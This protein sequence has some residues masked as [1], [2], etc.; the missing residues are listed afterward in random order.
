MSTLQS[1]PQILLDVES[2]ACDTGSPHLW[3]LLRVLKAYGHIFYYVSTSLARLHNLPEESLPNA[4]LSGSSL[5]GI[6]S[7][8]TGI[9]ATAAEL[10]LS[11]TS[12]RVLRLVKKV[13]KP[14]EPYDIKIELRFLSEILEDELKAKVFL[15]I[16]EAAIDAFDS[17][18]LFG[19]DV[20]AAF[21]SAAFD[22]AEAGSCF[23]CGRY[24]AAIFHLM[25]ATEHAMR[26][27]AN[28]R[29]VKLTTKGGAYPIEMATWEDV[30]RQ[31]DKELV[32]IG[33]WARAKGD[34]KVQALEFYGSAIEELRAV[35]EAWRNPIM[36]AK[37]HYTEEDAAQVMAHVKRLMRVLATRISESNRTPA[38]W[39]KAQLRYSTPVSKSAVFISKAA[40]NACSVRKQISFLPSSTSET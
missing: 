15:C 5:E 7:I 28:D 13:K 20:L 30:L 34:V 24:T 18:N 8:L 1:L 17:P 26:V 2:A 36:H 38:V 9:H 32:R 19:E 3:S 29:R 22:V 12:D 6:L 31:M 11:A 33:A 37:R 10:G 16:P 27:L 40:A 35:K 21:P 25:C 39:T 23:A 14:L 4:P